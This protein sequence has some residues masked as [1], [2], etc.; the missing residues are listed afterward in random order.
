M[1]ASPEHA[2]TVKYAPKDI[3]FSPE[4]YPHPHPFPLLSGAVPSITVILGAELAGAVVVVA[5]ADTVD[6]DYDDDDD[7]DDDE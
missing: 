5:A 4:V 2:I 1:I 6:N 7:D 3:T